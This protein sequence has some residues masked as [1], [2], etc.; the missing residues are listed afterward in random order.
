MTDLEKLV[1]IGLIKDGEEIYLDYK[2]E[3][4]KARIVEGGKNIQTSISIFSSLSSS[5]S[6]LMNTNKKVEGWYN[7][8]NGWKWWKNWKG[9]S[10]DELRKKVNV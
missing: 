6:A 5:A 2:E 4:Y 1:L 7:R 9:D 10:L 8:V 3:S